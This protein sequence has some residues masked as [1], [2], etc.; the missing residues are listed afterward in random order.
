LRL[1]M[2]IVISLRRRT[3][4]DG[5]SDEESCLPGKGWAVCESLFATSLGYEYVLPGRAGQEPMGAL[6]KVHCLDVVEVLVI[7]PAFPETPVGV[8]TIRLGNDQ[9]VKRPP[10]VGAM[11]L[12]EL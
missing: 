4:R 10:T 7:V 5:S 11:L 6:L 1:L 8:K 2:D 12:F 9:K 3:Q